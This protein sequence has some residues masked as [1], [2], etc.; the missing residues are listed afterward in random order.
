MILIPLALKYKALLNFGVY[1]LFLK[2]SVQIPLLHIQGGASQVTQW[3]IAQTLK[4]FLHP[5]F[6]K[7]ILSTLSFFVFVFAII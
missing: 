4:I 5:H 3:H 2:V 7:V 1:V 6:L